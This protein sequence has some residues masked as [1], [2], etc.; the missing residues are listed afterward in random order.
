MN[1]KVTFQESD[2]DMTMHEGDI[3]EVGLGGTGK[4]DYSKISNKPSINGVTLKGNKTAAQ[5]RLASQADIED[6]EYYIDSGLGSQLERILNIEHDLN[7]HA[8]DVDTSTILPG[9]M[10]NTINAL[11]SLTAS[12]KSV[13]IAKLIPVAEGESYKVSVTYDS[14]VAATTVRDWVV[15]DERGY[16]RQVLEHYAVAGETVNTVFVSEIDGY[17]WPVVDV[18]YTSISAVG[19]DIRS[20]IVGVEFDSE[21]MRSAVHPSSLTDAIFKYEMDELMALSSQ[22]SANKRIISLYRNRIK[23]R[24]DNENLTGTT[25]FSF[26]ISK[27]P[28]YVGG[29]QTSVVRNLTA[30]DFTT[31]EFPDKYDLYLTRSMSASNPTSQGNRQA[32]GIIVATRDPETGTITRYEAAGYV[33]PQ[34]GIRVWEEIDNVTEK[35]P[36][37]RANKNI[38]VIFESR[39]P[40]VD[41]EW[42][43]SLDVARRGLSYDAF[44]NG[45]P[46][47]DGIASRNYSVGDS[48]LMH[49]HLYEVTAAI[50]SGEAITVG[51]NVQLIPVGDRLAEVGQ[52]AEFVGTTLVLGG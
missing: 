1:I 37:I 44:T 30:D 52:L 35:L 16:V 39:H 12:Q 13:T 24:I 10:S 23:V 51:T 50:A 19:S 4:G 47:N 41:Q 32:G 18:N 48:I 38:A 15:A 29:N 25:Y 20:R 22:S 14:T 40:V 49:D 3:F 42:T 8:I 27:T 36:A 6:L 11:A 5:L 17:L 2:L 31:I 43:L 46:E 21:R 33:A 26:L 34:D 28:R 9:Y 7:E 45:E